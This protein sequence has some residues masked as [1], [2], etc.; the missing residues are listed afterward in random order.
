MEF[1]LP[2]RAIRNVQSMAVSENKELL[3][4]CEQMCGSSAAIR[5]SN[6]NHHPN[7]SSSSH[8]MATTTTM[9]HQNHSRSHE[10]SCHPNMN[11]SALSHP[12]AAPSSNN[13]TNSQMH[14]ISIYKV[15]SR[16]CVRTIATQSHVPILSVSF[17]ADTN[18]LVTLE[19]GPSYRIAYWKWSNAK[20]L[21]QAAC[22][23]RGTRIRMSPVN[24]SII[25][26]SGPVV[27]RAWTIT[28]T[29][30]CPDSDLRMMHLI[31]QVREME[32]FVDHV[33]VQQYLVTV[34]EVG[35]LLIFQSTSGAADPSNHPNHHHHHHHHGDATATSSSA[36]SHAKQPHGGL[37]GSGHGHHV[38]LLHSTKLNAS[39]MTT[40][41][42]SLPLL[43]KVQ[44][45]TASA[46]GFVVAGTAG[47]FS[48][49][50]FSVR[51]K[52]T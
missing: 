35:T 11:A 15:S 22:P 47:L 52:M 18:Y 37:H 17:S 1:F 23:S 27:F 44:T 39:T 48:V 29:G 43:G 19:D 6:H 13:H 36:S 41:T 8:S 46:K 40:A 38:E 26:I 32:H 7:R 25:T 4:V 21:A 33:W 14:Q 28:N 50:E 16:T 49:Y 20:L 3:V 31:P 12:T 5:G 9:N 2:P 10:S 30:G 24:P 34:S 45:I 51:S 42:S